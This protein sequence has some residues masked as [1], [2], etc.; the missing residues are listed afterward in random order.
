QGQ[1]ITDFNPPEEMNHYVQG[2]FYGHPFVVES[3]IV[4]Y[5]FMNKPGIVELAAKTTPPAWEGG[6]HWA[7]N[8]MTFYAGDQFPGARGDAFVA[9]HGSWNRSEPAGYCVARV[10]FDSGRPYGEL[11]YA[12]FL[13]AEGEILGRPVDT[14]VAPDGSLLISDDHGG[15]VYRMSY[16][17]Q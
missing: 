5:E 14:A 13:T 3:R 2:G 9:Y 6:A 10:L 4:R 8:S 7:A 1:P 17:G 16:T 15:R 12:G 11:V